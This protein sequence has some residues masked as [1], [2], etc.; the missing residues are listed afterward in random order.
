MKNL[1]PILLVLIFLFQT[2]LSAQ[3][4]FEGIL[5]FKVK[6]QDKTGQMSD[7][8]TAL[9]MGTEQTYSIK[10]KKYK[11]VLN[12]MLKLTSFH[13]GKDTIFSQ[14]VGQNNLFYELT[15]VAEEKVISY[16][17]KKTDKVVLGYACELLEVKTDKGFHQYY[18]NRKLKCAPETYKN[19]K[20]GLWDF[21][22]EKTGSA[23]SIISISDVEDIKLSIELIAVD[24]K[25][26]DDSIFIKPD[27][28]FTKMPKN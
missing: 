25:K 20:M 19:H 24:R 18:F 1:K 15:S 9:Y 3:E 16:E 21:F 22:T 5:K 12:G 23:L 28:P 26:L 7:E 4:Y 27:L 11:S 10:G 6:A 8:E 2:S 14:M 13:E 17:F